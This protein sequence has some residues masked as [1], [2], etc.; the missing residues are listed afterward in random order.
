MAEVFGPFTQYGERP[1]IQRAVDSFSPITS[2]QAGNIFGRGRS[3][4]T[5]FRNAL[6]A[7]ARVARGAG[8]VGLL[9]WAA[10]RGF[11]GPNNPGRISSE[12]WDSLS[13]QDR[14]FLAEQGITD[15]EALQNR[16]DGDLAASQGSGTLNRDPI[17]GL[18]RNVPG[19]YGP[20]QPSFSMPM[21]PTDGSASLPSGTV[22][23]G[24]INTGLGDMVRPYI[25]QSTGQV[26]QNQYPGITG[27]QE[28]Q[29][30]SD[31]GDVWGG[32]EMPYLESNTAVS[33]LWQ[34]NPSPQ[35]PGFGGQRGGS[36][37]NA[38][39]LESV[40]S[41]G[42]RDAFAGGQGSS[43]WNNT[44]TS[45]GMQGSNGEAGDRGDI[46]HSRLLSKIREWNNSGDPAL[47]ARAQSMR[48]QL[49]DARD[50]GR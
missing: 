30:S 21:F 48:N 50:N 35:T 39:G 11:N 10:N 16:L 34:T 18:T 36:Y 44:L 20:S 17:S 22:T 2:R 31:T 23:V 47:I 29:Q 37:T 15:R 5:R 27:P 28:T 40:S 25:N 14:A 4:E 41:G 24:D 3:G 32:V 7:V 43:D 19:T 42:A 6:D 38:S 45:M 8:P 13:A 33:P 26:H 1:I 9:L 46:G 12:M 49:R